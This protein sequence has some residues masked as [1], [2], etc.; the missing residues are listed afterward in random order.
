M[1]PAHSTLRELVAHL[2]RAQRAFDAGRLDEAERAIADALALDPHN[3]QAADLRQRIRKDRRPAA[4]DRAAQNTARH[5]PTQAKPTDHAQSTAM[6][7][8]K[9]PAVRNSS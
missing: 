9:S 3:V 4:P 7:P 1:T 8:P 2:A 5:A 6:P